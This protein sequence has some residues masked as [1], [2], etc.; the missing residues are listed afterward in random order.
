MTNSSNAIWTLGLPFSSM[1][2]VFDVLLL[3][4][5][6]IAFDEF[7]IRPE[8]PGVPLLDEVALLDVEPLTIP[9]VGISSSFA[10]AKLR[11]NAIASW[12]TPAASSGL[13]LPR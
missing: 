13:H 8:L 11:I 9:R 7:V 4:L 1:A 6:P 3:H 12:A 2:A 5:V 10:S